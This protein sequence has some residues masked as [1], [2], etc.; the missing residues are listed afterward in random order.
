M[1]SRADLERFFYLDDVDRKLIAKRRGDHSRLG[2]A[3]QVGTVRFLGTFLADPLDVPW[4][5]VD[6][7]AEQLGMSDPSGLK[8][9]TERVETT[10]A[11]AREIRAVYGYR[12]YAGDA[13]EELVGFV[14][15][16]AWT[17]G[18]GPAALFEQA[19]AWLRRERVLLPGVTTLVRVVQSSRELAQAR[20]HATVVAAVER[21]DLALLPAL[22]G[23][24]TTDQGEQVSRLELLRAG[25]TRVSG[26]ELE[27]AL[28][29]VA[30]VRAVGAG[31]VD[32]SVVPAARVRALARAGRK[33]AV[34]AAV[35]RASPYGDA[36][37]HGGGA[38][39]RGGR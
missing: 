2:F 27:K 20:M 38:G 4:G 1:L 25:P 39:S 6:Y 32:L 9:Y 5:M 33:G 29:R 14:F 34:V 8:R 18:E 13:A 12:E 19:E 11:H 17:H 26:P 35:G 24:L 31:A 28:R 10:N 16:R 15:S 30:A 7:L 3:V 37:G 36:G 23:L 21:A 22:R